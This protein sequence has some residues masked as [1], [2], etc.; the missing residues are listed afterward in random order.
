MR[1]SVQKGQGW[2][3]KTESREV[4]GNLWT[5][6]GGACREDLRSL[7]GSQRSPWDRSQLEWGAGE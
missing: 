7:K 3:G 5:G 1:G 4:E 2:A 6:T